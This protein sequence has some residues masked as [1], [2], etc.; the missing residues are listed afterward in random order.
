MML[1]LLAAAQ[2]DRFGVAVLDMEAD[3]VFVEFAAGIEVNH[4]EHDMAA[5]DDIEGR[6]EDVRWN[7]HVASLVKLAVTIV[8]H[9]EPT[10]RREAP[11]D[12]RLREAIHVS[13]DTDGLLRRKCSSQGRR[14]W[15]HFAL[16]MM[17]PISESCACLAP[18][19]RA[20]FPC[21]SRT[22]NRRRRGRSRIISC[23]QRA[24]GDGG[25]FPNSARSCRPRAH[26]QPATRGPCP[27]SR[28]SR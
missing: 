15:M 25:R 12:D 8:R 26:P 27:R 7:G 2:I 16:R 4:A 23:R 14:C 3:G 9:C 20:W 13:A 28:R 21:K 18:A 22:N 1:M 19:R 6:I 17:F 5:S 11:P 24:S 10:G